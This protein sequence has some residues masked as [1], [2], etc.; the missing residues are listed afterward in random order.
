MKTGKRK[1]AMSAAFAAFLALS[2]VS[3]IAA[4][5]EDNDV[6]YQ[7]HIL[8]Q[9][10]NSRKT[11]RYCGTADVNNAWKVWMKRSE[12][13]AWTYTTYWLEHYNGDTVAP[14]H[15]IRVEDGPQYYNTY[16][17]ASRSTVYLTAENNN[18][19]DTD[20]FVSGVWDEETGKRYYP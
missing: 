19:N 7:F 17:S 13:G 8:K 14:S 4:A 1:Y 12:E 11:G 9:Q 2:A 20:Y 3:P 10:Q 6:D 5:Y 18:K 15:S 16:S